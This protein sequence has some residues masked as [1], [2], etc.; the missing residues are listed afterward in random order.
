MR[1]KHAA[2]MTRRRFAASLSGAA[3]AFSGI[4]PRA[5]A[6]DGHLEGSLMFVFATRR[7][8]DGRAISIDLELFNGFGVAAILRGLTATVGER[9]SIERRRA[10][11][12]R[13]FWQPVS[14]I[15]LEPEEAVMLA[16]PDYR[17]TIHGVDA[18]ADKMVSFELE[19]DFG[20][21]GQIRG[22]TLVGPADLARASAAQTTE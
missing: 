8:A 3:L 12:G 22:A 15:R 20:P 11:F 21:L 7:S 5:G 19:A 17:L 1:P 4:A 14:L 10:F 13:D 6:H 18:P 9:V 16:P 2:P